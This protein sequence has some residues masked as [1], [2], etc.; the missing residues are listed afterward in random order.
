MHKR[1]KGIIATDQVDTDQEQYSDEA[2]QQFVDQAPGKLIM[3]DFQSEEA[4]GVINTAQMTSQGVEITGIINASE[5]SLPLYAAVAFQFHPSTTKQVDGIT[6][7]KTINLMSVAL[8]PHHP[9]L[10]IPPIEYLPDEEA[11]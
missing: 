10:S 1:F 9:D 2:L 11:V 3:K 5:H 4:I 7:Y 6:I 8:R